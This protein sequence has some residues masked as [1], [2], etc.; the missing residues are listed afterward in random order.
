[1]KEFT[2]SIATV[3]SFTAYQI[4]F[5]CKWTQKKEITTFY[6]R[7]KIIFFLCAA[8]NRK[9]KLGLPNTQKSLCVFDVSERRCR[10]SSWMIWKRRILKLCIYMY[11]QAPRT[12]YSPWIFP[13]KKLWKTKW[14]S[15]FS[16]GMH[17]VFQSNL[18]KVSTQKHWNLLTSVYLF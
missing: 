14:N 15:A 3:L 6:K 5:I 4:S 2:L 9:K 12:S 7:I 8:L 1:M 17:P 18:T 13:F 10:E 11:H 16:D